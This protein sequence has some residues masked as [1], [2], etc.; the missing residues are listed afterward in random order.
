MSAATGYDQAAHVLLHQFDQLTSIHDADVAKAAHLARS[1]YLERYKIGAFNQVFGNTPDSSFVNFARYMSGGIQKLNELRDKVGVVEDG[2]MSA[3]T[4]RKL[5]DFA[6]AIDSD[7]LQSIVGEG[8]KLSALLSYGD[9]TEVDGQ[10]MYWQEVLLPLLKKSVGPNTDRDLVEIDAAWRP[11]GGSQQF[12]RLDD[13]IIRN[14]S[15]ERLN[16]VIIKMS[17]ENQWG[18]KA[19]QYYFLPTLSADELYHLHPHLRWDR[20]KLD[21][22][23]S[24]NVTYS[25]WTDSGS[26]TNRTTRLTNPKP[27]SDPEGWRGNYLRFDKQL[28]EEGELCRKFVINTFPSL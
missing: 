1:I 25:I 15:K 26:N 17:M 19:A 14:V 21:F 12:S 22:T 7:R 27:N 4:I 23:N 11:E 2:P 10:A 24:I 18:E 8:A 5:I 16:H 3:E 9:M 6:K 20:R 28:A 13:Y